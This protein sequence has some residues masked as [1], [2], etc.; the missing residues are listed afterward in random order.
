MRVVPN[1]VKPL[2]HE[3]AHED[4]PEL[5]L[6]TNRPDE[7][8]TGGGPQRILAGNGPD[9]V[10]A[11]GGPDVVEAGNGDDTVYAEGGPDIVYGGN[12]DDYLHGG[13]GPDTLD[14]GNGNDT[15]IG[16]MGPDIL[17]GGRGDDIFVFRSPN[18]APA[19]GEGGHDQGDLGGETDGHDGEDGHDGCG[20]GGSGSGG[21]ETITDFKPGADVIDVSEIGTVE[22]FAGDPAEFSIWA[23]QQGEDTML[24]VDTDGSI[25]GEHPAEMSILLLDV[26]A[27]LLS[28][29]DFIF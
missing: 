15:L 23:V 9:Q 4:E 12:G 2:A 29:D 20:A 22:A 25:D 18:E 19:H 13:G 17:T 28:A 26:D 11:G 3:D 10:R 14:G 1:G 6:G 27:A 16:C 21:Q 24:Y 7:I 8:T 5:V